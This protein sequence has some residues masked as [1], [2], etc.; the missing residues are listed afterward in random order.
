MIREVMR[1][2][3]ITVDR[4]LF[5]GVIHC[6]IVISRAV[7]NQ[8]YTSVSRRDKRGS[9]RSFFN[10]KQ[11]LDRRYWIQRHSF[12]WNKSDTKRNIDSN[13]DFARS[14]AREYKPDLCKINLPGCKI[15]MSRREITFYPTSARHPVVY[16][17]ALYFALFDDAIS[18]DLPFSRG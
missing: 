3:I 6:G 12:G 14:V 9:R 10:Y 13:D 17:P 2:P 11:L 15:K 7:K 5:I 4:C 16:Y 1:E 8:I 18:V